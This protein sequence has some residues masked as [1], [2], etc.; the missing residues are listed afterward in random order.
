[1][2]ESERHGASLR[3]LRGPNRRLAPYRSL[4]SCS[5]FS[6]EQHWPLSE[7]QARRLK[8]AQRTVCERSCNFLSRFGPIRGY[9]IGAVFFFKAIDHQRRPTSLMGGAHAATGF[10]MKI[11]VEQ[12]VVFPVWIFGEAF[13]EIVH[14]A[15]TVAIG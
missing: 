8:P 9:L 15:V 3:Y 11:L 5:Q 10:A 2:G 13:G 1:M 6:I 12:Q 7:V 14:G 4:D